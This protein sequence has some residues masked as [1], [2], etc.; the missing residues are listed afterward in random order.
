[1]AENAGL[2]VLSKDDDEWRDNIISGSDNDGEKVVDVNKLLAER[3]VRTAEERAVIDANGGV[4]AVLLG[5][6]RYSSKR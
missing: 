1:M 4:R 3:V 6:K 5:K 2:R